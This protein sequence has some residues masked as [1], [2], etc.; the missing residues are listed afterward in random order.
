MKGSLS[1]S[2]FLCPFSPVAVVGHMTAK[3]G[4]M[5]SQ[6]AATSQLRDSHITV[7]VCCQLF[8]LCNQLSPLT[9]QFRY[10]QLFRTPRQVLPGRPS[11]VQEQR[12]AGS[13][14]QRGGGGTSLHYTHMIHFLTLH[15]SAY[16]SV[17]ARS[18]TFRLQVFLLIWRM[19]RRGWCEPRNFRGPYT[20]LYT[21]WLVFLR[22]PRV[23]IMFRGRLVRRIP[24]C[25]N[26]ENKWM[27]LFR[28]WSCINH[29]SINHFYPPLLQR[30]LC[31]CRHSDPTPLPL[32]L[33][34]PVPSYETR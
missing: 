7:C 17:S 8:P 24:V 6:S 1:L 23:L 14:G 20:S 19:G 28:S 2:W 32:D 21:R 12:G 30:G 34:G 31:P 33:R 3:S 13:Q 22:F 29:L 26:L 5:Q 27:W 15:Q 4:G 10:E 18:L 9:S 11:S 25:T 16:F